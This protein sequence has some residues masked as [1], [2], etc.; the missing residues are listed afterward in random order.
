MKFIFF[1]MIFTL[2]AQ[3]TPVEKQDEEFIKKLLKRD[4][5]QKIFEQTD[6]KFYGDMKDYKNQALKKII[7]LESGIEYVWEENEQ[8]R[9]LKVKLLSGRIRV[10][11][12][13]ILIYV[14]EQLKERIMTPNDVDYQRAEIKSENEL[15]RVEI[16]KIKNR[17]HVE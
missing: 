10:E 6:K 11:K 5:Y 12:E 7:G 13:Q 4:S 17:P 8:A 9:V 2:G 15:I 1:L 16:P 3:E 14:D